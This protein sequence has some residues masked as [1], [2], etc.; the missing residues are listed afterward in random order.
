[1]EDEGDPDQAESHSCQ[2]AQPPDE[3]AEVYVR[4]SRQTARPPG[5]LQAAADEY[6]QRQDED[7]LDDAR[8]ETRRVGHDLQLVEAGEA[9][10]DTGHALAD[11]NGKLRRKR[12][13]FLDGGQDS[14][15][16]FFRSGTLVVLDLRRFGAQLVVLDRSL[17]P[18]GV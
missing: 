13:A 17:E 12:V 7:G 8:D 1:A 6:H 18:G 16:A 2:I 14:P 5:C 3:D 11:L 4:G 9:L 15:P 10:A